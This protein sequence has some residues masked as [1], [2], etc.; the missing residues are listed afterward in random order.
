MRLNLPS[1]PLAQSGLIDKID[2]KYAE[3]SSREICSQYE[4]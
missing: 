3:T 2:Y 1:F 4:K